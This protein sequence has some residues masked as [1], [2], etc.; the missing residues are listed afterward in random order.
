MESSKLDRATILAAG[1]L[2]GGVITTPDEAVKF[3]DECYTKLSE[4]T[5]ERSGNK[6]GSR[7]L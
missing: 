3:I 4:F 5:K 7:L 2:A 1:A 6:R